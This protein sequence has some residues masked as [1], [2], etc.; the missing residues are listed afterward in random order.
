MHTFNKTA[1]WRIKFLLK[2]PVGQFCAFRRTRQ[3]TQRLGKVLFANFFWNWKLMIVGQT[4]IER[5]FALFKLVP[6]TKKEVKI[7]WEFWKFN[8]VAQ[9]LRFSFRIV[10][11]FTLEKWL[12]LTWSETIASALHHHSILK[13]IDHYFSELQTNSFIFILLLETLSAESL[14]TNLKLYHQFNTGMFEIIAFFLFWFI[15]LI[16]R[17][18]MLS[19]RIIWG[20]K[21]WKV[22]NGL[23][24]LLSSTI[25]GGSH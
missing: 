25:I 11:K 6:C 4:Y 16:L 1:I 23:G 19:F 17:W 22:F 21:V 24:H 3:L 7:S 5:D 9:V 15:F 12:Q 20:S 2:N 8:A 18:R 13:T 10:R 14:L